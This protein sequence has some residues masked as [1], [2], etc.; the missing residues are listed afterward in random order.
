MTSGFED[1]PLNTMIDLV[2]AANPRAVAGAALALTE[3][4][5]AFADMAVEL[6]RRL[7]GVAWKGEAEREF[8]RF[9][10]RLADHADDL[11]RY[12]GIVAGQLEEAA[13]GLT[14]VRNSMPPRS[15]APDGGL[16]GGP[17][18]PHRQEAVNQL[19][20]L[21]SF[22]A[23]A[24]AN[25][26]SAEP[27]AFVPDLRADVP[28]PASPGTAA[29]PSAPTGAGG[30]GGMGGPGSAGS[31]GGPG[32]AGGAGGSGS[33]PAASADLSGTVPSA[34]R[35][36]PHGSA[37]AWGEDATRDDLTS[38]GPP[39]PAAPAPLAPA[40][41]T[42]PAPPTAMEL[43]S[44]SPGAQPASP[45]AASAQPPGP[46]PAPA[47]PLPGAI[48]GGVAVP[49]LTRAVPSG[50]GT[51]SSLPPTGAPGFAATPAGGSGP[52][53]AAPLPRAL[54]GIPGITG[55]IPART[56]TPTP[57]PAFT[58]GGAGLVRSRSAV[59]PRTGR[60]TTPPPRAT[61][62][63]STW[64]AGRPPATPAVITAPADPHPP[65]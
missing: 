34:P 33:G 13:G 28:R 64:T 58:Q 6:R 26:A 7:D 56:A 12:A 39:H 25:L 44:V 9:G 14:S 49:L 50:Y 23:V 20:R 53:P 24:G 54:P 62:D 36:A 15:T 41:P 17:A 46:A 3:V 29:A 35:T 63:T 4:R 21:A 37:P 57:R 2:D 5:A 19:N 43:N 16:P 59:A 61:E 51:P 1:Q 65:H 47:Q 11:G 52:A 38:A 55:G 31:M 18:E 42:E 32:S 8:R 60:R 27:P 10:A 30:A 48:S 22:Y 45:P 40:T